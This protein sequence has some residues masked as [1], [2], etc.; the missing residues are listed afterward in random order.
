MR[1]FRFQAEKLI[2][3][4]LYDVDKTGGRHHLEGSRGG[5]H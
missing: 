2:R 4:C 5:A 1:D 3:Q